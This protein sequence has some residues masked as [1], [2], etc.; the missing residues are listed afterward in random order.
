MNSFTNAC[1]SWGCLVV[2]AISVLGLISFFILF[3]KDMLTS[4]FNIA[5][6]GIKRIILA[7]AFDTVM[8]RVR[9]NPFIFEDWE[10]ELTEMIQQVALGCNT[11]DSKKKT[12]MI[13]RLSAQMYLNALTQE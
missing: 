2:L 7:F 8:K 11:R 4:L 9:T 10:D 1:I 5:I 13:S 6:F 3:I 12:E